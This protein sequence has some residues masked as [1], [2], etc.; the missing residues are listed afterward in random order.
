MTEQNLEVVR[1]AI[2]AYNRGDFEA[3]LRAYDPAVE[4][5][6]LLLGTHQ[7]KDA[8]RPAADENRQNISDHTFEL[9]DVIAAGPDKVVAVVR[10]G[11]AGRVSEIGLGDRIAFLASIRDGLIVRQE[12]FR[13]A[14]EALEAAR[15]H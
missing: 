5:V 6:T 3:L 15:A 13:N 7:G 14:E 1:G 8:I 12:T 2:A 10:V 9:E 11:G 4:F